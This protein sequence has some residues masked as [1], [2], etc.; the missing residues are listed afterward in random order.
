MEFKLMTIDFAVGRTNPEDF[1][2]EAFKAA[3]ARAIDNEFEALTNYH[4]GLGHPR[5]RELLA[6]RESDREG[7]TVDPDHLAL[8]NGSMQ[9]VTLVAET[10][11]EHAEDHVLVEEFCYP[12]TLAAYRSLGIQMHGVAMDEEGMRPDSLEE[13]LGLLA[14]DNLKPRFIYTTATYQNPTGAVML[15]DRKLQILEIVRQHKCILVEDNCYGDVHYDGDKAPAFY[16]LEN[17][18]RQIYIC[19]LS[20]IFAPGVRLGYVYAQPG[21]LGRLLARRND[22]GGNYFAA[23][24]L[25]EYFGDSVWPHT[26]AANVSLKRKRDIVVSS[27]ADSADELCVWSHPPGGLFVWVRYPDDVDNEKLLRLANERDVR[28][29]Q[30][31]NF[32][33]AAKEC[34]YLRLAFGHVPDTDISEGISRLSQCIR[35]ARTSNEAVDL[36]LFES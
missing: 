12:G 8:M 35:E 31:R 20:K 9:G 32:H 23:A 1:P 16:A 25:A 2:V 29:G 14:N 11:I 7:V 30:G 33:F 28:Y 22:A 17:D 6:A 13:Q 26:E 3:A 27:L 36:C 21:M 10:L 15:R 4:I 24:V 18:E 34:S 19:S 5:L